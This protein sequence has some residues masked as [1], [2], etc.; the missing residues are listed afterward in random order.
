MNDEHSSIAELVSLKNK[1]AIITGG[2]NG[3]GRGIVLRLH[4]AGANVVVVDLQRD[5]AESVAADCNR[6]RPNSAAVVVAD[7]SQRGDVEAVVATCI[8]RFNGIDILV[9]N[10]GI[11][12]LKTLAELTDEIFDKV[13][14][15]NLRGVYLMTQEVV[16]KMRAQGRGGR[17][18]N[19]TSIDALHPSMA[20]LAAYDG[21][22]HGVWGFTKNVALEV[23][24]DKIWVN[25]VAP[26]GVNT[27]GVAAMA[28]GAIDPQAIAKTVPAGRMGEPDDIAR[29]VLFL[30]SDLASY[31]HGSQLVVDGGKLLM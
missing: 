6:R 19:V 4:E 23:A 21:S 24:K 8:D 22:K 14:G 16:E 1:T 29:A 5:E 7:V 28:G 12:P 3:I 2:A 31:V 13:I 9:N 26:G 25:A 10:A 17:I 18:V 15:V 11:F 27:P 30:A 20:G